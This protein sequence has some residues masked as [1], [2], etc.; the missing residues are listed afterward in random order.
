VFYG[1]SG[2]KGEAAVRPL[3]GRDKVVTF[4]KVI[5]TRAVQAGIRT[6]AARINGQPGV[7]YTDADGGLVGVAVFDILDGKVQA[8]RSVVNP[9]KLGHLGSIS[10]AWHPQQPTA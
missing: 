3:S 1:D 4:L 8:I 9:D 6:R 7:V 5:G 10:K 2:G